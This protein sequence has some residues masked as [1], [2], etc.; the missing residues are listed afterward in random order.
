MSTLDAV[1]I[2]ILAIFLAR[3]IWIGFIRQMASLFALI[4]GFVVA[5]RYYG[6]SAHLVTPY[7]QNKQLGF[8]VA[9][10]LL[11][12]I[13][14]YAVIVLGILLKRVMTVS[15]LG[16][17][18]RVLGAAL[19]VGKGIFV[20]CLVFMGLAIFISGSSPFFNK[21]FFYP[22]LDNT[23]RIII[24]IIKNNELRNE[25]LPQG[26]AISPALSRTIELGKELTGNANQ[27]ADHHQ[28][29]DQGRP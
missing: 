26:P 9:Y 24:S 20:A 15:L 16:W 29:V 27:E 4:L 21:S 5:G 7:I 25:L 11:F 17:F 14:F 2:L 8:F 19:G 1:V 18:D 6:Q 23:S 28:L 10:I 13:A 22:H 12:L 3:G